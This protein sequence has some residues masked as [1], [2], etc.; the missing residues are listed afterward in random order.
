MRAV[1][2]DPI[3]L[4]KYEVKKAGSQ[5]AV[6]LAAG[7]SQPF[8]CDVLKGRRECTGKLLAY[9]GLKRLV[10]YAPLKTVKHV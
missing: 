2:Y 1:E 8:L 9:L 6:A 5:K 3:Q 10:T 7:V 4:L